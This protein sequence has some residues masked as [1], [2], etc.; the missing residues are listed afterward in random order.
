MSSIIWLTRSISGNRNFTVFHITANEVTIQRAAE[1]FMTRV[2]EERTRVCQHTHETAFS[3]PSTEEHSSVFSILSFWSRNHHP[4]TELNLTRQQYRPEVPNMVAITSLHGFR[5]YRMVFVSLPS[6][7]RRSRNWSIALAVVNSPIESKPK[8]PPSSL[9]HLA[10]VVA[11][12]P[13]ELLCPALF[14]NYLRQSCNQHS[15]LNFRIS[16]LVS[17]TAIPFYWRLPL[18]S[19][20]V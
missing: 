11:I 8:C 5:L 2:G 10:V 13:V 3:R 17:S 7:F 20:S 9:E 1:V 16:S 15:R 18:I 12:A 6:E 19:A 14:P 4:G